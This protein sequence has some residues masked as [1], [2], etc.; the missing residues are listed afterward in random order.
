MTRKTAD[1]ESVISRT[2]LVT[3]QGNNELPLNVQHG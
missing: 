3:C 2:N 1:K